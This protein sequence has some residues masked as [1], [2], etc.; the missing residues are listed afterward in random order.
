MYQ[1]DNS[2]KKI[3]LFAIIFIFFFYSSFLFLKNDNAFA[4]QIIKLT[5]QNFDEEITVHLHNGLPLDESEYFTDGENVI[6]TY[7]V[8]GPI[9]I[10]IK[11]INPEYRYEIKFDDGDFQ[12]ITYNGIWY[13]SGATSAQ[14][15]LVRRMQSLYYNIIFDLDGGEAQSGNLNQTIEQG[16]DAIEPLNISKEGYEFIG[17]DKSIN[18]I[19]SNITITALYNKKVFTVTFNGG[20]GSLISGEEIQF[21][22]YNENAHPPVYE[23]VGYDFVEWDFSYE[24]IKDNL[25]IT[26]LYN[27]K[28]YNVN[29][30]NYFGII[31]DTQTV[32]Y[33]ST[34]VA[35]V[36]DPVPE[37][38]FKE[39][40]I[41]FTY[42]TSN[43]DVY[44]LYEIKHI[45]RFFDF[46]D[47]LVKEEYVFDNDPALPPVLV[48]IEGYK[49]IEWDTD[50]S[51]IVSNLE[52]KAIYKQYFLVTFDL[53]GG[54]SSSNNLIQEVFKGESAALPQD[55]YK[56]GHDF[57]EWDITLYTNI[58]SNIYLKAEYII[59]D[60][61]INFFNEDM[62]LNYI[63]LDYNQILSLNAIEPPSKDGHTFSHWVNDENEIFQGNILIKNN[64]TLYAIFEIIYF[65]VTFYDGE[66]I[67]EEK[68]IKYNHAVAPSYKPNKDG[69][70]FVN[71][72][73][74]IDFNELYS[75]NTLIT[76]DTEI[77]A[78]FELIDV[79][80]T[81][82][83]S[84]GEEI[85]YEKAFSIINL[86][87]LTP[88]GYFI[89][90]I[91]AYDENNIQFDLID[92]TIEL[93]YYNLTVFI[94][95]QADIYHIRFID[96]DIID[97]PNQITAYYEESIDLPSIYVYGYSFEGYYFDEEYTKKFNN[98]T[99]PYTDNVDN[100]IY[101]Y[102]KLSKLTFTL[103]FDTQGGDYVESISDEY[104]SVIE[105]PFSYKDNM[106]FKGWKC[107]G[108]L[109]DYM[110]DFIITK[111]ALLE[112]VFEWRKINLITPFNTYTLDYGTSFIPAL[113]ID[114]NTIFLGWFIDE[115]HLTEFDGLII[116][117]EENIYIYPKFVDSYYTIS[118]H[119]PSFNFILN[120]KSIYTII[121][122]CPSAFFVNYNNISPD[123]SYINDLAYEAEG[124]EF[125]GWFFEENF[126]TP[127]SQT[128]IL[129]DITLYA[130]YEIKKINVSYI[131]F[132]D[133]VITQIQVD[134]LS[135]PLPPEK[136]L[137]IKE[138]YSFKEWDTIAINLIEDTVIKAIYTPLYNIVFLDKDNNIISVSNA[139]SHQ[140]IL[141]SVNLE[142]A[143]GEILLGWDVMLLDDNT[144]AYY[145]K[146]LTKEDYYKELNAIYSNYG[147]SP[148]Q[149]KDN[150]L[151]IIIISLNIAYLLHHA[152]KHFTKKFNL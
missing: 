31:I 124:I 40:S 152:I 88:N 131:G 122:E 60:Y 118:F 130:K 61:S 133:A 28:S 59:K 18:N 35:P 36:L 17:W 85:I 11:S 75:I 67:I 30:Y 102:I 23:K 22:Y 145:P 111:D 21:I 135:T 77:Y 107:D 139:A 149:N 108:N 43:L 84:F 42:I 52:I 99:M 80:I 136:S 70:N 151:L 89:S 10:F 27:V 38:N 64:L 134:Y 73:S 19:T 58:Q 55:I 34:A 37:F 126:I 25:L 49:F 33:G 86:D 47:N 114:D 95:Y 29:F 45:V 96:N 56:E 63:R 87:S 16:G 24:N 103:T 110:S 109:I 57:V 53:D 104:L 32:N 50:Y 54:T 4:Y 2:R 112:A 97:T 113:A 92:N 137:L 62:L 66:H 13:N 81:I 120:D 116:T 78:K 12:E 141:K 1:L 41:D 15:I 90:S 140:E 143:E 106:L 125:A 65:T 72:F 5:L 26:A 48:D 76:K 39:W 91:E 142:L 146:I 150:Y 20:G 123:I 14:N 71:W 115:N 74:D 82:T 127:Y 44:P 98:T 121:P 144:I 3:I 132:N 8:N 129:S 9:E 46:Y 69:F 100:I 68:N 105:L 93:E 117:D 94:E 7:V 147:D 51:N 101:L 79:T 6:Y 83:S 128:Y 119:V 138:N 148:N